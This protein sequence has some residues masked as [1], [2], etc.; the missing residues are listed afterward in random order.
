M[1]CHEICGAY[2][3][4]LSSWRTTCWILPFNSMLDYVP[5]IYTTHRVQQIVISISQEY[6]VHDDDSNFTSTARNLPNGPAPRL[7]AVQ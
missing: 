2:R 3:P 4:V 1:I 7:P 5:L 6:A